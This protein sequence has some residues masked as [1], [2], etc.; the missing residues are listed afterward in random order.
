MVPADHQAHKMRADHQAID[1]QNRA[2]DSSQCRHPLEPPSNQ[3]VANQQATQEAPHLQA[4]LT[5]NGQ[6]LHVKIEPQ[7]RPGSP[8]HRHSSQ[9]RTDKKD[10][11]QTSPGQG[12]L[13]LHV[14]TVPY[15]RAP[16]TSAEPRQQ[17]AR[18]PS[19]QRRGGH[20]P[21]LSHTFL[22]VAELRP[23]RRLI[24]TIRRRPYDRAHPARQQQYQGPT[25]PR[26]HLHHHGAAQKHQAHPRPAP[27]ERVPMRRPNRVRHTSEQ[28]AAQ[29]RSRRRSI[30]IQRQSPLPAPTAKQQPMA[31]LDATQAQ[32]AAAPLATIRSRSIRVLAASS[33]RYRRQRGKVTHAI[34]ARQ[35]KAD[36]SEPQARRQ[37]HPDVRTD[38]AQIDLRQTGTFRYTACACI[39]AAN[40]LGF[41]PRR[42]ITPSS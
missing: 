23:V 30:R 39:P 35:R 6:C 38:S 10:T 27:T 31:Q 11:D 14:P 7:G 42:L 24:V 4:V 17:C 12:Q 20:S 26:H 25:Q 34:R 1:G 13:A 37:M 8:A 22:H 18:K 19:R 21:H 9:C 40:S 15:R 36:R 32:Q 33:I 29:R 16:T 5:A 3:H 28:R 41:L 2:D